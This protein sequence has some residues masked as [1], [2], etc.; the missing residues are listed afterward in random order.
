MSNAVSIAMAWGA[1]GGV[2]ALYLVSILRRTKAASNLLPADRQ[3]WMTTDTPEPKS[4]P[5]T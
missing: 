3:R 4:G 2:F 1:V 5:V